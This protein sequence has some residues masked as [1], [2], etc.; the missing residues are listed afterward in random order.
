MSVRFDEGAEILEVDIV[1]VTRDPVG[2]EAHISQESR[3]NVHFRFDFLDPSN[4]FR[5]RIAHTG[6][7]LAPLVTGTVIGIPAGVRLWGRT[8]NDSTSPKELLERRAHAWVKVLRSLVRES[9]GAPKNRRTDV[10]TAPQ[11]GAL[12]PIFPREHEIP[13]NSLIMQGLS[14][15]RLGFLKKKRQDALIENLRRQKSTEKRMLVPA[16]A[17]R[18]SCGDSRAW[19]LGSGRRGSSIALKFKS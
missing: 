3:G 5:R 19:P 8:A 15:L 6:Q 13:A 16:P 2:V 4:G 9:C 10:G 12:T 11:E 1:R 17:R 7:R 14:V 18:R